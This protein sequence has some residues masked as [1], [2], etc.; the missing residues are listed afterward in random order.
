MKFAVAPDR[1]F[2]LAADFDD[3]G[4][5]E[6]RPA[7]ADSKSDGLVI[8]FNQ[9]EEFGVAIDNDRAAQFGCTKFDN[10]TAKPDIFTRR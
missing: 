9:I 8:G 1:P 7:D 4:P 5:A 6:P 3:T 2:G 10:L